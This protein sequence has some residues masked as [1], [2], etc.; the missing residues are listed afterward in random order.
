[1]SETMSEA[2]LSLNFAVTPSEAVPNSKIV[3]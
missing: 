2:A 1:M 3:V